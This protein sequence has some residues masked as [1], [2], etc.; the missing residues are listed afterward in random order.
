MT[1]RDKLA[2]LPDANFYDARG[3]ERLT[4]ESPEEAV[5]EAIDNCVVIGQT[6]EA[7]AASIGSMTVKAYAPRKV[8]TVWLDK[9]ADDLLDTI[10]ERF[11][12][13]YGG[14]DADSSL[15]AVSTKKVFLRD[16]LRAMLDGVHVYACR[17]VGDVTLE[18]ADI[19]EFIKD[20]AS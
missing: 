18:E 3:N 7:L 2:Q 12:D 5:S 13:E 15:D 19:L 17:V 9:L 4:H 11:D 8:E 6:Q 10:S 20:T 1:Y 16:T 14:E